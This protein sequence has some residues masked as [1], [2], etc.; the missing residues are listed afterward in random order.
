MTF[1]D[2]PFSVQIHT[3]FFIFTFEPKNVNFIVIDYII[4]A[5]LKLSKKKLN[6]QE[7]AFGF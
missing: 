3:T 5:A 1:R 4:L 2:R 6:C 7:N